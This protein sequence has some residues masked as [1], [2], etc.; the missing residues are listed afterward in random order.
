MLIL[1]RPM[2]SR[3]G[4]EGTLHH[5]IQ[6]PLLE[7]LKMRRFR[8]EELAPPSSDSLLHASGFGFEHIV[9]SGYL[10]TDFDS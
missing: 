10:H 6:K 3:G 7:R 9:V 2:H 8:F 5:M 4:A 1:L